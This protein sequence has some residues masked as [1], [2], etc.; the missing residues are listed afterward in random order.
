MFRNSVSNDNWTGVDEKMYNGIRTGEMYSCK[1][2]AMTLRA[3]LI[4]KELLPGFEWA[5]RSKRVDTSNPCYDVCGNFPFSFSGEDAKNKLV[6]IEVYSSS[7]NEVF[8]GL[9]DNFS[10]YVKENYGKTFSEVKKI[11]LFFKKTMNVLCFIDPENKT[12]IVLFERR[13][14]DCFHYMQLG[15]PTYIPWYFCL[16]DS[17]GNPVCND[18]GSEKLDLSEI[19]SR[20]VKT[21]RERDSAPYLAV[22][23][24]M[25]ILYKLDERRIEAALGDFE[26]QWAISA[27]QQV[28]NEILNCV[29]Q[30][31]SYEREISELLTKKRDKDLMLIGIE[32]KINSTSCKT[33]EYFKTNKALKLVSSESGTLRFDCV[34]YLEVFDEE[35]AEE[36]VNNDESILYE[37]SNLND[38]DTEKFFNAIFVD[39][40]IRIKTC[41]QYVLNLNRNRVEGIS[42]ATY[43][44]NLVD[45]YYPNPHIH[46]YSCLG[47]YS[48]MMCEA[49]ESEDIITCFELCQM[50]A[51]SLNFSDSTVMEKFVK[52]IT[53]MT[54]NVFELPDGSLVNTRGVLKY[55]KE[56][57]TTEKTEEEK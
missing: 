38:S 20:L 37:Y 51:R 10:E 19:E 42:D 50:S 1:S 6:F 28:S 14:I 57:E 53:S 5:I 22:L 35:V 40:T 17:E 25:A 36:F 30:I 31:K 11:R 18:D 47:D 56:E 26:K 49:L 33:L 52:K 23:E 21:L 4:N 34:G 45:N 32:H 13:G 39:K 48:R 24:E 16:R 27:R 43:S 9:S 7:I 15:I 8:D 41:A 54:K 12:S 29:N 2:M 3:L 55:V 46:L 44:S